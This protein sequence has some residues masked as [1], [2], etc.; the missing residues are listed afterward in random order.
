M[1]YDHDF[2]VYDNEPE[3]GDGLAGLIA[4]VVTAVI[5]VLAIVGLALFIGVNPNP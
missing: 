5:L 4:V 2:Y 1:S 3:E